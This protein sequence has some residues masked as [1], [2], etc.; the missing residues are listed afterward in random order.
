ME[1]EVGVMNPSQC[2]RL[3]LTALQTFIG[4]W[5]PG[6]DPTSAVKAKTHSEHLTAFYG[7]TDIV[8]AR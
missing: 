5:I 7:T 3:Q 2:P 6:M 8:F 1:A 4:D